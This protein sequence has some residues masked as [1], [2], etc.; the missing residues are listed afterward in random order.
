M[1]HKEESAPQI[2]L[3]NGEV[4]QRDRV[5][6]RPSVP[7]SSEQGLLL[8]SLH[9]V[10]DVTA[11]EA[12]RAFVSNANCPSTSPEASNPECIEL[13]VR[14]EDWDVI[15]KGLGCDHP[16]KRISMFADEAACAESTLDVDV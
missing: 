10:L 16:V 6:L 4:V 1:N 9:G 2:L 13:W 3:L 14:T 11:V 15:G 7:H 8:S 5:V 12:P